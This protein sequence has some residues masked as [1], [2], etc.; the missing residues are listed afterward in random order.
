VRTVTLTLTDNLGATITRN[1][2]FGA[3][4]RYLYSVPQVD[5][6]GKRWVEY[7]L[8]ATDGSQTTTLGPVRVTLTDAATDP[9][10]LNLTEG[11]FVSGPVRVQGTSD[12]AP[13]ALALSAD[14]A[15]LDSATP[16]LEAGPIFAF[17]AT[18]TDAFFRNGVKLGDDVL[19]IFDEG[20]YE[21]IVT[22]DAAVPVTR[23]EK[24]KPSPSPSRLAPRPSP[25]ATRT[26]TTTTSRR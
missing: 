19:K 25:A 6:F 11:Q 20:Y 21:R 1:L 22:V 18:N 4:N 17:E 26:R 5:L 13:G 9:V 10:R 24:G 14:G 2:T 15:A 7:T 12:A 8:T 23:V 16:S 3:A